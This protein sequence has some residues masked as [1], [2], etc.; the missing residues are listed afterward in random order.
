MIPR[1]NSVVVLGRA[2]SFVA[3]FRS[4]CLNRS[5]RLVFQLV[6]SQRPLARNWSTSSRTISLRRT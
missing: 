3:A 1:M 5:A 2:V 6:R 4:Q